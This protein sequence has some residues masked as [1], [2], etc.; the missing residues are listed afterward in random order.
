MIAKEDLELLVHGATG[1]AAYAIEAAGTGR[2]LTRSELDALAAVFARFG[3]MVAD[4]CARGKLPPP[5][6]APRPHGRTQWF[7]PVATQEI[8]QVTDEDI[9][10]ATKK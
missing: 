7:S 6:P 3:S 8:R 9:A 1:Q 2:K 5:P 10:R 4:G